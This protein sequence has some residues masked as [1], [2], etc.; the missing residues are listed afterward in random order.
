MQDPKGILEDDVLPDGTVLKKGSLV[1]YVP[2]SMARMTWLWGDDAAQFRPR[3]WITPDG[4]IR[5]ESDFKFTAFQVRTCPGI[6]SVSASS[7]SS[8]A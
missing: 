1:T 3:R 2:Y 4:S 8:S 5:K 7:S 6:P